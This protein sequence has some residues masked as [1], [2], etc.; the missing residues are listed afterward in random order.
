MRFLLN[1]VLVVAVVAITGCAN[2][3]RRVESVEAMQKDMAAK[4]AATFGGTEDFQVVVTNAI[5][6]IGTVMRQGTTIPIDFEAC[7]SKIEIPS[8]PTPSLF[9]GYKFSMKNSMEFG[10]DN[11]VIKELADANFRLNLNDTA[12]YNVKSPKIKSLT[13]RQFD[14]LLSNAACKDAIPLSRSVWLV[15]GYVTG[16]R[17]FKLSNNNS[18]GVKGKIVKVASFDISLSG[19][20]S[21]LTLSDDTE[22][23]FLQIVS[24]VSKVDK[25][26]IGSLIGGGVGA[27]VVAPIPNVATK[28]TGLTPGSV[29]GKIYLQRDSADKSGLAERVASI[30]RDKGILVE[31][32]IEA[33]PSKGMPTEA[34]VRYFNDDDAESANRALEILRDLQPSA[35][36]I[37]VKMP[38][39]SGQLEI[40]M[41]RIK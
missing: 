41:A 13:D 32:N 6:P 10:L 25:N 12:S 29:P 37:K 18:G 19:G 39:P 15:R 34:Q 35:K 21:E 9:P 36:A 31:R 27:G 7:Q 23:E 4:V 38:A 28:V 30:L 1:F 17:E 40:W 26:V 22:T 3:E 24:Q 14:A 11:A 33:I 16:K 2:R 5:Y 20:E 8:F